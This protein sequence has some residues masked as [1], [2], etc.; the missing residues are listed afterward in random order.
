MEKLAGRAAEAYNGNMAEP[1]SKNL[2]E[3]RRARFD[4]ALSENYE[5]GIELLGAEVKS[6]KA[7]RLNLAGSFARVRDGELW[8]T[9]ADLPANQPKNAPS[10]YDPV[11]PRRLLLHRT[12]IKELTGKLQERSWN[13]VPLRAYL[14]RGL[15]KIELGL[16]RNRKAP[17]KREY[18]RKKVSAREMRQAKR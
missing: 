11:R 16:G 13:L 7:G 8:L 15:V 14:K 18:L 4:Y 9:N 12:E 17:D 10:D 2:A 1:Q 3:N 5:A 6:V